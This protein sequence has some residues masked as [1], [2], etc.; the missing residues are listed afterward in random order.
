MCTRLSQGFTFEWFIDPGHRMNVLRA[1]EQVLSIT[2]DD[3]RSFTCCVHSNHVAHRSAAGHPETAPLTECHHLHRGNFANLRSFS[4]DHTRCSQW[5]SVAEEV[6]APVGSADETDV[7][8]IWF[9]RCAK[10]ESRRMRPNL[11]FCHVT[12]RKAR[13]R[14][15]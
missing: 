14:K 5:N 15:S 7:L 12:D 8:A 2:D 10:A 11:L 1:H 9:H 4:V 3:C 13:V 6:F